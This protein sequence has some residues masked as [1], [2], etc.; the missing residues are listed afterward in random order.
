MPSITADSLVVSKR[1]V[2][3][4]NNEPTNEPTDSDVHIGFGCGFSDCCRSKPTTSLGSALARHL[5]NG[6][7]MLR[8]SKAKSNGAVKG[9]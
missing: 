4:T 5:P 1:C 7:H 2:C 8:F 3:S 6:V 9:A